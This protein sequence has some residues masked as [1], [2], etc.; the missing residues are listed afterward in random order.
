MLFRNTFSMKQHFPTDLVKKK[1]NKKKKKEP[2]CVKCKQAGLRPSWFVPPC[3]RC[4]RINRKR[5][6]KSK[7]Q[8]EKTSDLRWGWGVGGGGSRVGPPV[9]KPGRWHKLAFDPKMC[10]H[11]PECF[12]RGLWIFD[13]PRKYSKTMKSAEGLEK[14][15][16]K[17]S[18]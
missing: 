7:R 3:S 15:T 4:C 11:T 5:K 16:N 2:D 13:D 12:S 10:T 14:L 6:W 8:A 1:K 17:Q 9:G 18:H